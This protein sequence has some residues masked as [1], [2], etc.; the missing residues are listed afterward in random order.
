MPL[1]YPLIN[2][3]RFDYSN[4]EITLAGGLKMYGVRAISYSHGLDPGELRGNRSPL[5]GRTRGTYTPEGSMELYLD[6]YHQLISELATRA[7]GAGFMEVSF[8]ISVSYAPTPGAALITDTLIG[9]RLRNA[10]KDYSEGNDAL[11][12]A[13][14]LHIME[15]RENGLSAVTPTQF[16]RAS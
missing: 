1:L 4:V 10:A 2:G 15:I 12:V 6:E 16:F 11:A 7:A 8:Q 9:C 14:D 13:C 3:A 5:I